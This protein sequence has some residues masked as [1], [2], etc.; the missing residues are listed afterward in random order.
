MNAKVGYRRAATHSTRKHVTTTGVAGAAMVGL[1]ALAAAAAAA[2]LD[3]PTTVSAQSVQAHDIRLVSCETA[4][5][6]AAPGCSSASGAASTVAA[7]VVASASA[8]VGFLV[9]N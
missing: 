4:G 5:G 3:E 6:V 2:V 7:S 1:F 9:G 8:S